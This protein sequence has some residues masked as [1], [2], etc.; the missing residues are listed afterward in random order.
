[1][2]RAY[3]AALSPYGGRIEAEALLREAESATGLADWGGKRW[4]EERF[5]HDFALLCRSIEATAQVS[6]TG[7]GRTHSRLLTT[8]VSRLRYLDARKA[9]AADGQTICAPIIGTGM[10]RAGTT[11]L[12]GLIAADPANRPARAWEAAIPAPLTD[13][14]DREA[15]YENILAF[16]GMTAPDVTAIHPFGASLPEECIF[17]QEAD[18]GSLY[19]VYWTVPDYAAATAGKTASAFRW[20][21]GLMQ[22]LQLGQPDRRWALK[23][24]GHLFVWQELLLAFP[25][26]HIYVNHRDPGKV[27]PSISSLFCKLKSLFSDTAI[28]PVQVG[29]GQLA[30]WSGA[31]DGYAA[32][33][34]GQG[35]DAN[36]ADIR[37]HELT[38]APMD[39]VAAL[40]DR[41][42]LPLTAQARAAM[43]RHLEADHH[44]KAPKRA[45]GLADYG[46]SEQAIEAAFGSYIDRFG[47]RREKRT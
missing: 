12:H 11:F 18:I 33:R 32:W 21:I 22:Y 40:Y 34:G 3:A 14:A 25:D 2:S 39:T 44:A 38:A 43:E 7:R 5:R 23:S 35:K 17:L 30:A 26:A 46:L 31:M 24:P 1:M 47:I 15:L 37:F 45:Y 42:G 29:T 9:S 13:G 16:Q 8:L 10:P 28:D 41:F 36:V 4:D 27:I 6:E 20:Q 19:G